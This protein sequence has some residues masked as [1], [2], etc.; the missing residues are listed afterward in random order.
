MSS[1]IFISYR[2]DE[3]AGY[4]GRLHDRLAKE[5][6]R[7]H[8]FM[9]VDAIPLGVNFVNSLQ[10]A[11]AGCSVLLVIIGPNW[12]NAR[13]DNNQRRLDNDYDFV[14]LEL[15]TALQ[16]NIPVVP[17]L[18]GG[19]TVP[20]PEELPDNI[21]ELSMRNGLEVHHASFHSDIDK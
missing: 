12:L 21:R 1:K 10:E 16:R 5:F 9:D 2:R 13:D 17:I 6:G 19:A 4:A 14:R 18:L 20:T 11:I 3:T 8:L 15:A 7:D